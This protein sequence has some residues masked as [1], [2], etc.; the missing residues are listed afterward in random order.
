MSPPRNRRRSVL[1]S[2]AAVACAA[3]TITVASATPASAATG[4]LTLAQQPGGTVTRLVNPAAGCYPVRAGYN[5][6]DNRLDTHVVAYQGTFCTG[7]AA[8]IY[9]GTAV[10]LGATAYSVQVPS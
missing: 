8:R 1:L 5:F 6:V 9:P 4:Q 10:P 3:A 7:L 2:A